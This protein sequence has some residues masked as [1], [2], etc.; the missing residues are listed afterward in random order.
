MKKKIVKGFKY[1]LLITLFCFGS[2]L[3]IDIIVDAIY[4]IIKD[5]QNSGLSLLRWIFTFK[6]SNWVYSVKTV[7]KVI[8]P[9]TIVLVSISLM[10]KL[11]DK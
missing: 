1:L 5:Y 9:L 6:I 11:K 4:H 8:I 2:Y 7:F 3:V 10:S